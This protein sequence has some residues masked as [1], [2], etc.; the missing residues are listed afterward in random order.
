MKVH[1]V[2]YSEVKIPESEEEWRGAAFVRCLNF[3]WNFPQSVLIWDAMSWCSCLVCCIRSKVDTDIYQETTEHFKLP[4]A[5]TIYGDA[6]FHSQQD[7]A[8]AHSTL[9]SIINILSNIRNGPKNTEELKVPIKATCAPT[10]TQQ[11]CK[12]MASMPGSICCPTCV[13]CTSYFDWSKEVFHQRDI[14]DQH[15]TAYNVKT[16]MALSFQ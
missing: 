2:Y 7:L 16:Q 3:S 10:R 5:D 1:F 12:Q 8:P 4:P 6:D 11:C 14:L 13:H 9:R 15:Y